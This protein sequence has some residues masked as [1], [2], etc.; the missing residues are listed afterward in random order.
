MT[1]KFWITTGQRF[2][3][4]IWWW[5]HR[6]TAS[7]FR[8]RRF[9]ESVWRR[10]RRRRRSLRRNV[11]R[12]CRRPCQWEHLR[13]RCHW[14]RRRYVWQQRR[15]WREWRRR[16]ALWW[17][18]HRWRCKRRS[19]QP[20]KCWWCRRGT[21]W[22]YGACGCFVGPVWRQC[23]RGRSND[24]GTSRSTSADNGRSRR[25][26][27]RSGGLPGAAVHPRPH[28][29][30]ATTSLALLL[31]A[32]GGAVGRVVYVTLRGEKAVKCHKQRT[33]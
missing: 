23:A 6:H 33:R 29:R 18:G 28:P 2:S 9:L 5:C 31:A 27:R 19:I 16:R 10:Q 8:G 14:W 30:D 26:T 7:S 1:D 12:R 20:V 11:R 21:L 24:D 13:W 22:N 32:A 3:T 15:W 25:T 4:T 17:R